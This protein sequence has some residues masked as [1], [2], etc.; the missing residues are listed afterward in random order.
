MKKILVT[1]ASGFVGFHLVSTAYGAGYEV[2]AAVRRSSQI[3]DITPFV[4]KFVYPNF[5][6]L[7]SWAA[8]FASE[9]YDYVI[10]AAAM[11]KAKSETEM[12]EANV[13]VTERLLQAAFQSPNPPTRLVY[14]SSLA[15]IAPL[16]YRE[17]PINE[18]TLYPPVTMYGRSKQ[19]AEKLI[20]AKFADK[21][22]SIIRPTAVY[23]PREKVLFA[24]FNTMNNGIDAYVG[25]AP[26]HL[27]FVYGKELAGLLFQRCNSSYAVLDIFD[28]LDE[29]VYSRYEIAEIFAQTFR[30]SLHRI[31]VPYATVNSVARIS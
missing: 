18:S 17:D 11:T 4:E 24:L 19:E 15:A 27:A 5:N 31:N 22:I 30:E 6:Q 29:H 9:K 2:H 13:G 10:H 20:R 3:K 12:I 8:L 26:Q 16:A 28:I 7:E 21:P 23:G 1:G 14:V 25:R